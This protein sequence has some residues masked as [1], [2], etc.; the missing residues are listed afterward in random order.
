MDPGVKWVVPLKEAV[1][2]QEGS[3]GGKAAKLAQLAQAGFRTPPGFLVTTQAY[4]Y[5]VEKQDLVQLIHME[6]GRKPF[7]S[8]RWE[9]IWDVALRIR[10]A[11]LASPVPAELAQAI[12]AAVEKLGPSKPLAVRSSAPGEDSAH[13]SFA[14]LHE[15]VVGVVG[16]A[17]VLDAVRVVWASLWSDAALLYRQ[18][19][20]L[21]PGLSRMAVVIQ[22][23]IDED[24]S[25][26]AFGRDPRQPDRER[27][28]VEAV[29][30]PCGDLVD[31]LVDPDRWI[32]DR[33]SGRIIEWR[34]GQREGEQAEGPILESRDLSNLHQVLL[35]VESLFDWPADTEWTG[36]GERFTL[37]QARPITTA[38]SEDGDQ[39]GWYLSLRPSMRRLSGL[40]QRVTGQLIP[41]LE[42]LGNR[43]S[44]QAIQELADWELADAIQERH[45]A[46]EKWQRIYIEDFIPFAHGVRQLGMYYN[47]V[48]KPDDPYQFV[49]LLRGQQMV[50]S[51]R[52]RALQELAEQ[53]REDQALREGL[54]QVVDQGW[55]DA[56]RT[57]QAIPGSQAL[58]GALA[59]LQAE[60]MDVAYAGERLSD[61]P[62]LL[63]QTILEMAK[64][65][66]PAQP[67][68]ADAGAAAPMVQALEQRLLEAVG[69][70]RREE[71]MEVLKIGRLSWR[72]RDDD[73]LLVGRLESQLLRALELAAGRLRAAG[74]LQAGGQLSLTAAL[75]L[76]EALRDAS[77]APVILPQAP[78]EAAT[79]H[80][81]VGESPRQLIGQ[82][83]APGLATGQVRRVR[84][85]Q[86]L[87]R[88][89]AGEVLVCDAIQ[90]T[91]THLVPLACAIVERRGGMLIHGAI[92]ARELGIPCVNGISNAVELL[93]AG[94]IVTVDGYLGIVTVGAPEFD[95]EL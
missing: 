72:L 55:Q 82:P 74:R 27:A 62:D 53:V 58:V 8:M 95:L 81:A 24:R 86:D 28:I 33:G 11:F 60:F 92:I 84:D 49:Q 36:R 34:A 76:A 31:G 44:L 93:E 78:A 52:N 10:S 75:A 29:P 15:S 41:E 7:A 6:L 47:D 30:G 23:M 54:L 70:E 73:N 12:G 4:E 35:Q 87:G 94:Q 90:P 13:R 64:R 88:F 42:E 25:G 68:V 2:C 91:M 32:L 39:R 5:F 1:D 43:F 85:T 3:I 71:A 21:D 89:R 59:N 40:A 61:R 17:A 20:A 63:L 50:A 48:V 45:A 65:P 79:A 22:E 80:G 46:L 14:G 26:V 57:L 16:I 38:I 56:I 66:R 19:L 77:R 18:E 9:E 83:A 67:Q 51:R 37:L 69:P